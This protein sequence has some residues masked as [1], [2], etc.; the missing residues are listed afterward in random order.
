MQKSNTVLILRGFV[1]LGVILMHTS[2]FFSSGG[3]ENMVALSS[4]LLE[5]L[6]LFAVPLFMAIAGYLF[7]GRN[8]HAYIYSAAFFKKMLLSV[9]SPYLLFSTLYIVTAFVFDGHTYTLGEIV[10]DMLTGSAAV[11]LGFFRALIGFYLVYPFLIRIF[12]K[13]RE[14]GWLKYY[15]AAAAVLQISWKVLNNIQFETVWISY[16]LMGTMFLRYLVYFSLGMAAYYYKKEFLEDI[17][18]KSQYKS[19]IDRQEPEIFGLAADHFYSFS[20]RMLVGKVLLE[21]LLYFG[22]Y[23][24]SAQYVFIY[25]FD[26]D[27]VLS[28]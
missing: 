19:D 17:K 4:M 8:K 13:C 9:L 2:W 5:V 3:S 15:F 12:T 18:N 6:S 23:L 10:V 7:T 21:D 20:Y 22:V 26:S 1:V 11:H 14:S 24:F 16:L 25:D 27:A 28:F